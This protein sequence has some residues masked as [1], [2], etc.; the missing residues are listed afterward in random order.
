MCMRRSWCGGDPVRCVSQGG[1][2]SLILSSGKGHLEM[3]EALLAAGADM[4]AKG[5]V[6]G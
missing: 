3:V 4:V 2:T 5:D 6:S 1:R